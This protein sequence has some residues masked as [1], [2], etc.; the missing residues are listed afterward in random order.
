[1]AIVLKNKSWRWQTCLEWKKDGD[2]AGDSGK[3]MLTLLEN[4][5]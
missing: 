2:Y 3:H 4:A 5:K 1:M